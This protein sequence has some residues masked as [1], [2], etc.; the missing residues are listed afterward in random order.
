MFGDNC[1]VPS[2]SVVAVSS[3]SSVRQETP[4]TTPEE[5]VRQVLEG[6]EQGK[7][8]ILVDGIGRDVKGSLSS[9]TPAYLTPAH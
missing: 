3:A 6:L 2:R 4:K 7:E 5:V 9:A 8:E 1:F